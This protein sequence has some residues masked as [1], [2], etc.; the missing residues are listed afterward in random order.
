MRE[1]T[2]IPPIELDDRSYLLC[3][4]R[5]GD[6]VEVP[7]INVST[8]LVGFDLGYQQVLRARQHGRF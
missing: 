2:L 5:N 1:N 8:L 4:T 3:D 7:Q 6:S